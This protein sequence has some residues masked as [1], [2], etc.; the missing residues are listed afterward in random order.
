MNNKRIV[1]LYFTQ[2]VSKFKLNSGVF[3]QRSMLRRFVFR[4]APEG[5]QAALGM[6]GIFRPN[7]RR[8][9]INLP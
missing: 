3:E 8:V 5:E 9:G 6:A 1:I 4:Q 7:S 2:F